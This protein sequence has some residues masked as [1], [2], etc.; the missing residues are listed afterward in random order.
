MGERTAPH[1]F[2]TS[3]VIGRIFFKNLSVAHGCF[4]NVFAD[5]VDDV[6]LMNVFC[7]EET[8]QGVHHNINTTTCS[9]VSRKGVGQFRIENAEF[10]VSVGRSQT[11]FQ[12]TV[13]VGDY[14]GSTHFTTSSCNGKYC[15]SGDATS[16]GAFA[17]IIFP[18]VA[19]VS[20]TISN[21]FGAVDYATATN[22][23]DEVNAFCFAQFNAF[24]NFGKARV[25]NNAA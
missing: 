18:N 3:I 15:C 6:Q 22:S 20:K 23:E 14:G 12:P 25:G 10:A 2:C 1:N 21:S 8:F 7:G 9:L 5:S 17:F 11:T 4:Q 19:F 16:N 24:V 13:F